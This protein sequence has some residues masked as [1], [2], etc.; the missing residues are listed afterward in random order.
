M[1]FVT[2]HTGSKPTS[3]TCEYSYLVIIEVRQCLSNFDTCDHLHIQ[4]IHDSF[5]ETY[6]YFTEGSKA[7]SGTDYIKVYSSF[8]NEQRIFFIMAHKSKPVIYLLCIWYP[9]APWKFHSYDCLFLLIL[10]YYLI[11][12][13]NITMNKG[14]VW[15]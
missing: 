6:K 14:S 13:Y 1:I 15:G 11:F 7:P 5:C 3:G 12:I 8:F 2:V 10:Q 4:P 9:S